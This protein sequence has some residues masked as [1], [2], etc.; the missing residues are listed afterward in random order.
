MKQ[1]TILARGEGWLCLNKPS[2]TLVHPAGKDD[3]DLLTWLKEQGEPGELSA[4]HRLD[5][6]VSGVVLISTR[7]DVARA[8]HQQFAERQTQ[9]KYRAWVLGP[10]LLNPPEGTWKKAL[11]K[12][13]E[14]RKNP[15]GYGPMRV[16][17]RTHF[18][19]LTAIGPCEDLE[20]TLETGRK[21][22]LRRHCALSRRAILGDARY[23]DHPDDRIWLH[24]ESLVFHPPER[25]AALEVQA[26]L[27]DDW[28]QVPRRF[29]TT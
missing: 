23:G 21:H 1:P 24:A 4:V 22:Q 14:G 9:K 27:P 25:E 10:H 16:P 28:E 18:K 26:P 29:P 12:K 7:S 19:R 2:G 3:G 8:L 20:L 13:A 11:T 15:A 6:E 17:A 5:R